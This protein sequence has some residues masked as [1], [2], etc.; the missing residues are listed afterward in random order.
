MSVGDDDAPRTIHITLSKHKQAQ[1]AGELCAAHRRTVAGWHRKPQWHD[2]SQTCNTSLQLLCVGRPRA[3]VYAF[4][5]ES[6][7]TH[8]SQTVS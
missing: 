4:R 2:G 3:I 7:S 8:E 6:I 5:E 1:E